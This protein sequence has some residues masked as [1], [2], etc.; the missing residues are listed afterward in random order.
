MISHS[1]SQQAPSPDERYLF[2]WQDFHKPPPMY[3]ELHLTTRLP[4]DS[5]F[6]PIPMNFSIPGESYLP[7]DPLNP[8]PPQFDRPPAPSYDSSLLDDFNS[9]TS[10]GR[11]SSGG[12]A[13]RRSPSPPSYAPLPPI[14]VF[15]LCRDLCNGVIPVYPVAMASHDVSQD[16]WIRFIEDLVVYARYPES[17]NSLGSNNNSNAANI[18]KKSSSTSLS[19]LSSV[20]SFRSKYKHKYK[21]E[22]R[23]P[24]VAGYLETW[25]KCFFEPRGVHVDLQECRSNPKL[26]FVFAQE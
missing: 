13:V 14:Q 4:S 7:A 8:P 24:K 11:N 2:S 19:S 1:A 6:I 22:D 21:R 16:D 3:H 12:A 23:Y 5:K 18:D 9:S 10:G 15:A 17:C 25:N 20:S 26:V